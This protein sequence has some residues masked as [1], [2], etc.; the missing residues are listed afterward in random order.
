MAE[1]AQKLGA[2]VVK[3]EAVRAVDVIILSNPFNQH[4]ELAARLQGILENV[5][6]IDTSNYYPFRDGDIAD[7]SHGKAE[8]IFLSELRA[9]PLIKAWNA[10]LAATLKQKGTAA[11]LKSRIAIPLASDNPAE[12]AIVFKL[13]NQTGFDALE[14]ETLSG[15][16]RLQLGTPAY[17]TQL[18]AEKLKTVLEPADKARVPLNRDALIQ[19]FISAGDK[20]PHAAIVER[21]RAVTA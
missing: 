15:S 18:E 16:W 10:V 14:A 20:L 12:K 1:L 13:V 8:S 4:A 3:E 21:N 7:I 19:A 5:I 2:V 17:R 11:V 9:R 6:I